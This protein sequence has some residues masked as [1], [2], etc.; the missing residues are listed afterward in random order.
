MSFDRKSHHGRISL[1]ASRNFVQSLIKP[2]ILPILTSVSRDEEAKVPFPWSAFLSQPLF[3]PKHKLILNP[4]KFR[5]VY[6]VRLLE[7]CLR[8][9]PSTNFW[10]M[11]DK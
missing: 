8:K 11:R 10:Q 1:Q 4:Q 9:F 3:H 5:Q 6:Q 2:T 7:S